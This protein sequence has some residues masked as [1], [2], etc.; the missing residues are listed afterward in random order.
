MTDKLMKG[1]ASAYIAPE[2]GATCTI[3]TWRS[4]IKVD[5]REDLPDET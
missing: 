2:K 4:E 1:N 5:A 3:E